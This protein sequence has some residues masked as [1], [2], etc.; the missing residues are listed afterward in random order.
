MK[1]KM[2]EIYHEVKRIHGGF[3]PKL[4]LRKFFTVIL[5]P[6][7][8]KP[9]YAKLGLYFYCTSKSDRYV[10]NEV[11]GDNSLYGHPLVVKY[12]N[13]GVVIDV[14]AHKGYFSLF[15]SG[16][17][18][19]V[20]AVE[21]VK[22]NYSY[23]IKHQLANF[24][25]NISAVNR[26]LGSSRGYANI[27]LSRITDAR[28][29]IYKTDFVGDSNVETV[30]TITIPDLLEKFSIENI[31]LLKIDCEGCEYDLLLSSALWI[32]KVSSIVLEI[33]EAPEINFK[34]EQLIQHLELN[35]FTVDLY[36]ERSFG[37][38]KVWMAFCCRA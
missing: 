23:L 36:S 2:L 15:A 35:G 30:E 3:C 11:F 13:N 26:A 32:Q 21:P 18:K 31:D 34:K 37:N 9:T 12:L 16:H 38:F 8:G 27:H 22:F 1:N 28:N 4:F 20:I 7:F 19:K 25:T 29:S 5:S 17:A 24:V 33:H 6:F 14:G 10:F